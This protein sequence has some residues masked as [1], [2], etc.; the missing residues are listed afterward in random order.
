[1][2][3]RSPPTSPPLV[4]RSKSN[5]SIVSVSSATSARITH[6]RVEGGGAPGPVD[7]DIPFAHDEA[8]PAAKGPRGTD[9]PA[10]SADGLYA[11]HVPSRRPSEEST[12]GSV[13]GRD[14]PTANVEEP[15]ATIFSCVVN[16][17][18]TILGSGT[19]AM[20]TAL[21]SVGLLLGSGI[22]IFSACASSL[23]L[24]LLSRCARL[25]DGRN[26]SFFTVSQLTYPKASLFFD[27]AIAIKCFGVSISYLIIFGEVMPQVVAAIAELEPKNVMTHLQVDP[28]PSMLLHMLTSRHFWVTAAMVI[29]TPLSFLRRLDSLR[30]TS[31][32]ALMALIY[33]V[34]VV[35]VNF[36]DPSRPPPPPGS[37]SMIK[38]SPQF[39]T[40]LPIFVFAFT[41]H[42]NIFT[43]YNEL[44]DNSPRQVN[45]TIR[46][47][48]SAAASMYLIVGILGYLTFGDD[49]LPNIILMYQSG[50]M[51]TFGQ[52]AIGVLMLL[53]YPL[54]CH[55]CRACL[56]KVISGHV[57]PYFASKWDDRSALLS[58]EDGM[59]TP[60]TRS[61][62]DYVAERR[63]ASAGRTGDGYE[64]LPDLDDALGIEPSTGIVRVPRPAA[65]VAMSRLM[66]VT[67]TLG[68]LSGTYLVAM[69][70]SQLDLVL[71][72][73]GSTGSTTVS[74]IL[75]GLFFYKSRQNAPWSL[76]KVLSVLL[77]AYGFFIMTICLSFNVARLFQA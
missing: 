39:F 33:L 18:N 52:L 46:I 3:P 2:S 10:G 47:A 17:C 34:I 66:Y 57:L 51:V 48:V 49:V 75:P 28:H 55:P 44:R 53:S 62:G 40:N 20:P 38:L 58:G 43:V 56:D 72:F 77:A 11:V 16:L 67:V 19:L 22:V 37:V 24:Y 5:H 15:G 50:P 6:R 12:A 70:V 26:A 69:I 8:D 76:L 23:G 42:Q 27:L 74:F 65:P 32:V 21:A 45:S 7:S 68:I 29:L 73:V 60:S 71:A 9:A 31:M 30:Y 25:T 4:T 54:Q 59:L 13:V 1:M 64:A 14:Q 63:L 36:F 61:G 41:C 35:V